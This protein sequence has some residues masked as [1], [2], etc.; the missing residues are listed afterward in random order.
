MRVG[1]FTAPFFFVL[2]GLLLPG[3]LLAGSDSTSTGMLFLLRWKLHIDTRYSL[4]HGNPLTM[5]GGSLGYTW[6]PYEREVAVG[7]YW[8]GTMGSKQLNYIEKLKSQELDRSTYPR[9]DVSFVNV[10]YW[11]ILHNSER[12]KMGIPVGIG[13]GTA[14]TESY[15][16]SDQLVSSV[17]PVKSTILPVH[18]GGYGEWK[19]TRWV[20]VGVQS[21]YRFN[22]KSPQEL[23]DLQ[24]F[25]YRIRFIVYPA[26]IH[27]GLNYLFKG[28]ALPSPFYEKE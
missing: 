14:I 4:V 18:I 16:L 10:G 7:Y 13:I 11:H 25:F 6:G 26:A 15:T 12:W 9:S 22:L 20:G 3:S 21:G 17:E 19:A 8:L 24:G 28:K 27:D 2:F 5:Q 1:F 23:D